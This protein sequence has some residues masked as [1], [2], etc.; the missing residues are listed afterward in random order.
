MA[1]TV[2]T[3][4]EI[5]EPA[6]PDPKR[7]S[8]L[9]ARRHPKYKEMLPHWD[10]VEES[11]SGGRA[12]FNAAN[13]FRYMKEGDTEYK[14]RIARAYRFNHSREVVDLVDKYLFRKKVTRREGASAKLK[15]FWDSATLNGLDMDEFMHVVSQKSSV[16]GKPWIVID[17]DIPRIENATEADLEVYHGPYAYIVRP[18][19]VLD[20]SFD[21]YGNLNW[22]LIREYIRMDQNPFDTDSGLVPQFRLWTTE[23]WSL[24]RKVAR[25]MERVDWGWHGLG[26]V[27]ALPADNGFSADNYVTPSLIADIAYLDRACANYASNLDAIIQ[28][29]TFSQL[30][31]PAQGVLPGE[32]AYNKL[33]EMGTK[34]VFLYDGENGNQPVYLSPDPRQAQLIIGAIQQLINEIYHS[35]GLA[36]ERTKQDNAKG[37]DNS[38]G[39]AK[40]RDFER[41]TALLR[42]KA[43]ALESV[44]NKIARIVSLW[45]GEEAPQSDLVEYPDEFDVRGLADE[46]EITLSVISLDAPED[47]LAEQMKALI[48]KL[49]PHLSDQQSKEF[50]EEA[51]KWAEQQKEKSA[52]GSVSQSQS[53][54]LLEEARRDR[55]DAGE[56]QSATKQRETAA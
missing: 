51:E 8:Q 43:T 7:I 19:D 22:V 44:E 4:T 48:K 27:P 21:D 16:F 14:D 49:L 53:G 18:Q 31:M 29:Q 38:S 23:D 25:K 36:G 56:K 50:E 28:D 12:W 55:E 34:R 2:G 11:Y 40:S 1:E 37:I 54:R 39:V 52:V 46:I 9:I 30:A 15:E 47:V 5:S 6:A 10:F 3:T 20:A 26:E 17:S 33:L 45:N 32:D 41:V 24:F 42:A 35:V 13:V